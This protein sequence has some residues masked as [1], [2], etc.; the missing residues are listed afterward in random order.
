MRND[1]GRVIEDGKVEVLCKYLCLEGRSL[2]LF[3]C[4]GDVPNGQLWLDGAIQ[5]ERTFAALF[6]FL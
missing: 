2:E 4:Y 6:I 3:Q 5:Q 1:L